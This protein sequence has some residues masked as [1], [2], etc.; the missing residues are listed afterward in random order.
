MDNI[1]KPIANGK[2]FKVVYFDIHVLERYFNNPKYHMFYS[3]YRGD[4]SVKGLYYIESNGNE[5]VKIFGLAYDKRDS[6]KRAIVTFASDL[7][8]L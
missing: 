1:F 2:H 7:S 3:G 8:K 5:Y 4:I 6:N